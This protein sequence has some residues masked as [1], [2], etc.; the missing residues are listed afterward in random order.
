MLERD[1]RNLF[2]FDMINIANS[3]SVCFDTYL[4][5]VNFY[6]ILFAS[7]L[8]T[9]IKTCRTLQTIRLIPSGLSRTHLNIHQLIP[10]RNFAWIRPNKPKVSQTP[11]LN[12][13]KDTPNSKISSEIISDVY[14]QLESP[15]F[16]PG[17]AKTLLRFYVDEDIKQSL[18]L[19]DIVLLFSLSSRPLPE[20]IEKEYKNR[21]KGLLR[22][23]ERKELS[24]SI[25]DLKLLIYYTKGYFPSEKYLEDSAIEHLQKYFSHLQRKEDSSAKMSLLNLLAQ[26]VDFYKASPKSLKSKNLNAH[27]AALNYVFQQFQVE[28]F[29]K[30]LH[31]ESF[32]ANG[33]TLSS[34][35][36]SLVKVM[37]IL[38]TYLDE[39]RGK[40]T[41]IMKSIDTFLD[42][43]SLID[44]CLA[45][46]PAHVFY[47]ELFSLLVKI[48]EVRGK[49]AIFDHQALLYSSISSLTDALSSYSPA[50]F[51]RITFIMTNAELHRVDLDLYKAFWEAASKYIEKNSQNFN[52]LV[53]KSL[54]YSAGKSAAISSGA[55]EKL[56]TFI[57]AKNIEKFASEKFFDEVVRNA[58]L[59][60]TITFKITKS[61]INDYYPLLSK[62][63]EKKYWDEGLTMQYLI[64]A[65]A[66]C[67][68]EC[69]SWSFWQFLSHNLEKIIATKNTRFHL[70]YI[71]KHFELFPDEIDDAN[72]QKLAAELLLRK[73]LAVSLAQ[74]D[75]TPADEVPATEQNPA[76]VKRLAAL[77]NKKGFLCETELPSTLLIH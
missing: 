74:T 19:G 29:F 8:S 59:F 77:L 61:N 18:S 54:L 17:K 60:G 39:N 24:S 46:P 52:L 30:Q 34:Q 28:G 72:T 35:N 57:Q 43:I 47:E 31:I 56:N 51:S 73:D 25:D 49:Q 5:I 33:F 48:I 40:S 70:L 21:L 12:E 23:L 4:D 20:N 26:I 3:A 62:V 15:D 63:F 68:S 50:K 65:S 14:Q 53:W 69:Y 36:Y 67:R 71:A 64:I 58:V 22:Q 9:M 16:L 41:E 75:F 66:L 1:F 2:H 6:S 42:L 13:V 7:V 38:S 27:H 37:T 45:K 10:K 32:K 11:S 44:V 55:M 76:F